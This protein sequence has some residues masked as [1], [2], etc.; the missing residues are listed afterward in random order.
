MDDLD[1]LNERK[2]AELLE[3]LE[4]EERDISV[5]RRRLHDRIA[6]FPEGAAKAN[7]ELREREISRD[8]RDLHR[9]IDAL[10]ARRDE[11]RAQRDAHA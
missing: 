6:M 9:R 2:V 7:F 5:T 8:R 4:A 11:L 3:K 1:A 10:R